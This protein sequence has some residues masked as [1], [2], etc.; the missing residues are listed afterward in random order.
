MSRLALATQWS[1]RTR[2]SIEHAI[3]NWQNEFCEET[4]VSLLT[5]PISPGRPSS[6]RSP[7]GPGNPAVPSRPGVPAMPGSPG[8]PFWPDSPAVQLVNSARV[9]VLRTLVTGRAGWQ[10]S[11]VESLQIGYFGRFAFLTTLAL[12]TWSTALVV[13]NE[14]IVSVILK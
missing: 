3:S 11:Q 8:S 4:I 9:Q 7:F 10:E 5:G 6:P 13:Y 12:I 1:R 2:L 14:S